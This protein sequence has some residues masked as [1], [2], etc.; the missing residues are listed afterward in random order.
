MEWERVPVRACSN[1]KEE[2]RLPV[3]GGAGDTQERIAIGLFTF[4]HRS[5][6]RMGPGCVSS[7]EIVWEWDIPASTLLES[8]WLDSNKT[9]TRAD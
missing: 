9:D 6:A 5:K 7:M 1:G 8:L 4:L 2:T 3:P